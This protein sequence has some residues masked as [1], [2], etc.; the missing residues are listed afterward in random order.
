MIRFTFVGFEGF[1]A[2]E[3]SI[4][5]ELALV[6]YR[7]SP[8][9]NKAYFCCP[10]TRVDCELFKPSIPW[11]NLSE[12]E[13]CEYRNT[14]KNIH[15]LNYNPP[16][17]CASSEQAVTLVTFACLDADIVLVS[18]YQE[19][20]FLAKFV[21]KPIVNIETV[22][23]EKFTYNTQTEKYFEKNFCPEPN[24]QGSKSSAN[25]H[26]LSHCAARKAQYFVDWICVNNK[27]VEIVQHLHKMQFERA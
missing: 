14:T 17:V 8:I 23:C 2:T 15:G 21:R 9:K 13:R 19:Y 4:I 25:F 18:G 6:R 7:Y 22:G 16:I 24:H 12:S 26:I 3:E 10:Y 1:G 20:L 5:R 27:N 11:N